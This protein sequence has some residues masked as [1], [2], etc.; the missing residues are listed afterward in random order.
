VSNGL[1]ETEERDLK[2]ALNRYTTIQDR[3]GN[4]GTTRELIEVLRE[5]DAIRARLSPVPVQTLLE[6]CERLCPQSRRSFATL[7]LEMLRWK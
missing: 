4:W 6:R 1:T 5:I 2:T 3:S 7:M